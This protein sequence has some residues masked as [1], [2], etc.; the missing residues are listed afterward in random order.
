MEN[1]N[2]IPETSIETPIQIVILAGGLG[3]RLRP[4][5]EQIPKAMIPISEHPF[6]HYQL[7]WLSKCGIQE[8]LISTGYLGE[9]I[10]DYVQDG[11]KWNLRVQYTDEGKQLRG[12]AGA[13]R[14]ALDQGWLH[15]QFLVTYGD[16]FLPV[17]YKVIW[18]EFLKRREPALMSVLRNDEQW[19]SSNACFD[20]HKVTLYQKLKTPE[21]P[22][23]M[24]FIDYGLCALSKSLIQ[25]HVPPG[26]S[27]D[28]AAL[29]HPL[30]C[31]GSLAGYE[32]TQRFYEI[33]SMEGIADLEKFIQSQPKEFL[34]RGTHDLPA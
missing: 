34:I 17:D 7:Q 5:T 10:R 4:L 25:T 6:V 26:V 31:Q 30:S 18:E 15:D 24:R 23:N 28:L 33:G 14:L 27:M 22:Q 3:T 1:F 9:M 19:D 11:S 29:L 8:V 20:G 13:L 16:S 21:K 32:V 2:S 12:T